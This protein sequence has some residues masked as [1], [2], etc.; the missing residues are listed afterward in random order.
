MFDPL[1]VHTRPK[2]DKVLAAGQL[3][4]ILPDSSSSTCCSWQNDTR[5]KPRKVQTKRR[6]VENWRCFGQKRYFQDFIFVFKAEVPRTGSGTVYRYSHID[7]LSRGPNVLWFYIWKCNSCR[8]HRIY[9]QWRL[10]NILA[11]L[12]TVLSPHL[13][14]VSVFPSSFLLKIYSAWT[15][16]KT[17]EAIYDISIYLLLIKHITFIQ[18]RKISSE[19]MSLLYSNRFIKSIEPHVKLVALRFPWWP[20][21][22]CCCCGIM[23]DYKTEYARHYLQH[24]SFFFFSKTNFWITSKKN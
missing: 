17:H 11:T 8:A 13:S 21:P 10:S 19:N 2:V 14:A 16:K 3:F 12:F 15:N 1:P 5:E 20:E 7:S 24:H 18:E 6:S 22:G 23:I 4:G 9:R